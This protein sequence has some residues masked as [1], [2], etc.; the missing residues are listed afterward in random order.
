MPSRNAA[1]VPRVGSL[2]WDR[3]VL[4]QEFD[5]LPARSGSP[6]REGCDILRKPRQRES[7]ALT[8]Q[9]PAGGVRRDRVSTTSTTESAALFPRGEG[10]GLEV[11]RHPAREERSAGAVA[12]TAVLIRELGVGL[13][14]IVDARANEA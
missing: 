13:R 14:L 10:C 7:T 6:A 11:D 2:R 4:R 8:A 1:T 3:M 9:T 12:R 5:T